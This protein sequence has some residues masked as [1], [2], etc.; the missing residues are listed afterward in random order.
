M[1]S[2][3]K[4]LEL[5]DLESVEKQIND[6]NARIEALNNNPES[7]VW[8]ANMKKYFLEELEMLTLRK[9]DIEFGTHNVEVR[10]LESELDD[11][12]ASLEKASLF[13]RMKIKGQ[14][15]KKQEELNGYLNDKETKGIIEGFETVDEKLARLAKEKEEAEQNQDTIVK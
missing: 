10:N 6:V 12:N 13:Q 3:F 15:K 11:L 9:E 4:A 14:I 5:T 7:G 2:P 1:Q 8:E